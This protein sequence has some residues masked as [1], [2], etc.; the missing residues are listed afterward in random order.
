[1]SAQ[2]YERLEFTVHGMT[3]ASCV[4]RV[5][6]VLHKQENIQ[7]VNVSLATEKVAV[8]GRDLNKDKIASII[9]RAGF[10]AIMPQTMQVILNVEGMTC[11]SC[12]GRVERV[13]QKQQG[14]EAV[15]VNL[16][17]EKAVIEGVNLQ[18]LVLLKAIEKAGYTASQVNQK[19]KILDL[20]IQGMTCASCVGRVEKALRK[21]EG[22]KNISVNLATESASVETDEHIEP[23]LLVQIVEK[24]GYDAQL[25]IKNNEKD[26]SLTVKREVE[27][28]LF[29]QDLFI[30]FICTLPVFILEMGTHLSM[31]FHQFVLTHIGQQLSW[32]IQFILTTVVL[33]FPGR[34]FYK[35][36]LPALWHLAPDMNS[37][38]ALG[39]LA[40][41]GFSCIATFLPNL[42]P[43]NTINVYF[44]AAAVIVTLILLGRYLE[45][46]AKGK[47]SQ[48]IERLIGIQ[49]KT[50]RILQNGQLK[51]VDISDVHNGMIVVAQ[52]GEKIAVDGLVIDGHSFVDESMITG[53][54]IAVKKD[55]DS[56]VVA[57]TVN[58]QGILHIQVNAT[59]HDTVLSQI[60]RLV[61]EAQSS[62]LPIQS[63]VNKVTMW[64][65][66]VVIGLATLTFIAWLIFGPSPAFSF[67]LVNAVA[68]LIIACPCAMGLATP[69]S[70][71]VST[72]RGAEMGVLFRKGE[73]LQTLKEA[74]VI[75]FDKTG[76]LT[77]GKPKL[78]DLETIDHQ[79]KDN[80]LQYM[81]SVEQYSEHPV[82]EAIVNHAKAQQIPLLNSSE[83]RVIAGYGIQAVVNEKSVYIGADRFMEK[84]DLDI[85]PFAVK[86]EQLAEDGKTP[87]YIAIENLVVAIV[88]VA[89]D[90]KP[91]TYRAI[92][93]LHELGLKVVMISG[94]NYKTARAIAQKLKIDDV[95]AE[96]LPQGKVDAIQKLQQTYGKVGYVGDGINDAPALATADIGLAVG[97]GTDVAI[98]SADVVL[99]SGNLQTVTQ[100]IA[101]SKATIRNIQQNLFWAFIYNIALIPIAAGALYPFYHIL[102]SPMISAFAMGLSSVFVL[103]N[104]LRLKRFSY[105]I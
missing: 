61:E 21:V 3:C 50:A 16:A 22:V 103:T 71:M 56:H 38:V 88:A 105:P 15:S 90:I 69:T 46:K 20:E 45:A 26:E 19:N 104:A 85:K 89:D 75:A 62:K 51:E 66:P 65:V 36:G 55:K 76:T 40:A 64:F 84:L 83:V 96:V 67:A 41:Y 30:A 49:P 11:A 8:L 47:T 4:G 18:L 32:Y 27:A 54:P 97:T 48:A 68:V 77:E 24:A 12:V 53:E 87:F 7:D 34:R 28:Q 10:E 81:A 99:M 31:S 59:G 13:L 70:I 102:L 73:A 23:K 63:I 91:S 25:K 86:A 17:T 44:E 29:K 35:K 52:A 2:E 5:E 94:D 79:N 33:V 37:L 39:T 82:A 98:E 74:K 93:S 80:V 6:K 1:M 58:Q 42:L 9:E 72:G 43:Q 92:Q 78:T 14:V 101:L 95:I 100:A 57:G 60:I